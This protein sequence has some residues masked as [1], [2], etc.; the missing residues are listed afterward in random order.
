M[1][2]ETFRQIP[3]FAT[4]TPEETEDLLNQLEQKN[5]LPIQLFSGWMNLMI[6]C[7]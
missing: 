7:I 1:T 5:I 4:L 2:P 6:N 3:L